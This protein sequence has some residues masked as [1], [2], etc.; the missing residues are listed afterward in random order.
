MSL[1][2]VKVTISSGEI[3]N[4]IING[5]MFYKNALCKVSEQTNFMPIKIVLLITIHFPNRSSKSFLEYTF[6]AKEPAFYT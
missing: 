3:D 2:C 1:I 6:P 4:S 5:T